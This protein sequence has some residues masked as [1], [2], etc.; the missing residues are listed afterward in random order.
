MMIKKTIFFIIFA[1]LSNHI[2][3]QK[4]SLQLGDKYSED[5]I[6]ASISYAQMFSLPTPITKSKFSYALSAGFIKDFTLNKK[7]SFSIAGGVGYGYTFF[8]HELKV[9]VVNDVIV[10]ANA[11]TVSSNF[12]K[13]HNL[14]FP[15]EFR[16]RTSNANKYNFW[17]I[18][19][20]IKFL[21]NLSNSFE[22]LDANSTQFSYDNLAS[23]NSLQYGLTFSAGYDEFNINI[24]YGLTPIFENATINGENINTKILKFGLIFYIL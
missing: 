17:R 16:W 24:F 15:L 18:Y 20:G 13:S 8:N 10:F 21:Y 9:Y 22:Y 3:A 1:V 5:Q 6:Y 19:T 23:Y 11:N 12:F 14:E 4:D 7:G 2:S